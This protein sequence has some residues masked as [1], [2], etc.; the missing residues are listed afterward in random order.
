MSK[1][2]VTITTVRKSSSKGK[3]FYR[4][5]AARPNEAGRVTIV[6]TEAGKTKQRAPSF[7]GDHLVYQSGEI[8]NLNKFTV[9]SFLDAL[10]WKGYAD[11]EFLDERIPDVL[12]GKLDM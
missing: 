7:S 9:R 11:Y 2:I 10:K 6:E 3:T 12:Y 4:L 8:S 1:V 5:K